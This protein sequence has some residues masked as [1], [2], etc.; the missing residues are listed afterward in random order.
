[1]TIEKESLF[2]EKL[3]KYFQRGNDLTQASYWLLCSSISI[4][5]LHFSKKGT[6]KNIGCAHEYFVFIVGTII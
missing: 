4:S 2:D 6:A 1:M 5:H 3:R